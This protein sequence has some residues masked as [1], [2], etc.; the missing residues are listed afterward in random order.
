MD[1]GGLYDKIGVRKQVVKR[2]QNANIYDE[3]SGF[4]DSERERLRSLI[5]AVYD[6]FTSKAA[7]G[8]SMDQKKI[9][10]LAKGQVWTGAEAVKNGLVD[11]LGG[12]KEAFA[13]AKKRAGFSAEDKLELLEL[14][15]K[16]SLFSLFGEGASST[17]GTGEALAYWFRALEAM[18]RERVFMLLPYSAP[19][20]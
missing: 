11:E 9:K 17:L 19:S 8:R 1:L 18:Q 20:R 5:D 16:P 2:G 15:N 4:T 7:Q 10:E 14:P 3:A 13:A 12:L 6:D